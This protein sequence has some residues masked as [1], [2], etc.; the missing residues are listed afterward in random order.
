MKKKTSWVK[1]QAFLHEIK[2]CGP[3]KHRHNASQKMPREGPEDSEKD[4][5]MW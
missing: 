1:P 3:A 5:G 2:P 4:W